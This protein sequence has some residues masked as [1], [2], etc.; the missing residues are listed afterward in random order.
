[1]QKWEYKITKP[2]DEEAL[3][4][5]G[6]E[7]WEL[8]TVSFNLRTGDQS[9]VLPKQ[10]GISGSNLRRASTASIGVAPLH[11]RRARALPARSP[12][13]EARE[14]EASSLSLVRSLLV[15]PDANEGRTISF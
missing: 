2:L 12:K 8:A 3:N 4:K 15:G 5:L 14:R 7:G 11:R 10:R 13:V 6:S 1:M 9:G